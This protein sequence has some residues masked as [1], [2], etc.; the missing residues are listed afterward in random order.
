M[1][2]AMSGAGRQA[3]ASCDRVLRWRK[4][5]WKSQARTSRHL[6]PPKRLARVARLLP[7]RSRRRRRPEIPP[8]RTSPRS[9]KRR[10]RFRSTFPKPRR[11]AASPFREARRREP[12]VVR[13]Q[14]PVVGSTQFGGRQQSRPRSRR[15]CRN[16]G[17]AI[18]SEAATGRLLP[19]RLDP[20]LSDVA[21]TKAVVSD[22]TP[23]R[24]DLS[25]RGRA[26]VLDPAT[27]LV[28]AR[29][30]RPASTRAG[31]V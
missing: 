10:G 5:L 30:P 3:R 21:T 20:Q 22:A 4:A 23:E 26:T 17:V 11:Q 27:A 19:R 31:R 8:R 24:P 7:R 28:L 12:A 16:R 6:S 2:R 1:I 9:P 29:A 18:V 14:P 13:Q 15:D 25:E